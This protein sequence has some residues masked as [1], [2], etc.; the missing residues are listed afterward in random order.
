MHLVE[1]GRGCEHLFLF[2]M[3]RNSR[4]ARSGL[5]DV[6]SRTGSGRSSA[7]SLHRGEKREDDSAPADAAVRLSVEERATRKAVKGCLDDMVSRM[8]ALVVAGSED[9]GADLKRQL[10]EEERK[11]MAEVKK[12]QREAL[13]VTKLPTRPHSAVPTCIGEECNPC[14]Y[15]MAEQ[16]WDGNILCV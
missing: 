16:R 15:T 6:V 3:T 4:R 8:E 9:L 7:R 5:S 13:Q 11:R 12:G 14:L 1:S 10:R 2:P